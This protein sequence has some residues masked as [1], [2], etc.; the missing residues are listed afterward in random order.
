MKVLWGLPSKQSSCWRLAAILEFKDLSKLKIFELM[1]L[2]QAH[3][4]RLNKS[5]IQF[6]EKTFPTK[7]NF[8]EK[9]TNKS[10]HK[11]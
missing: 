4:E 5:L 1:G 6:V 9:K 11:K 7:L 3:E 10:N 2:L 8:A